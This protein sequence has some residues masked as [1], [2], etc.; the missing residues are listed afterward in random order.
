MWKKAFIAQV[1]ATA[2]HGQ[3]NAYFVRLFFQGSY[4]DNISIHRFTTINKLP[5]SNFT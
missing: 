3:I 4:S 5:L 2:N 1:T